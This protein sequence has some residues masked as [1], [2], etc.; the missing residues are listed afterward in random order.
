VTTEP[1][2]R[3]KVPYPYGYAAAIQS[4]GTVAA[5]LLAGVSAALV[6][7]V[8]QNEEAFE[9]ANAS[10]LALIAA[11]FGFLATVQC[12]FRA[13]QYAVTPPEIE[14]WHAT[15]IG[16]G[17]REIM[18]RE[19]RYYYAEHER[20]SDLASYAYDF[21]LLFFLVGVTAA[22]V[23]NG[24]LS[25]ASDGRL[26]VFALA[27]A[28]VVGEFIWIANGARRP[29]GPGWWPPPPGLESGA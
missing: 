9:W 22:T 19:Q 24:G 8:I 6:A 1:E 3:W 13:R 7:L 14:A 27:L 16:A 26:A 4:M 21:G 11:V 25:A 29:T 2:A 10:L 17:S 5:P 15:P 18:R 23:P 12:A 28:G 20:W